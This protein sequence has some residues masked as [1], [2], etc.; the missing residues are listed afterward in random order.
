MMVLSR[1]GGVASTN[2][3][4]MFR[5]A[6]AFLAAGGTLPGWRLSR[7]D[8]ALRLRV[9]CKFMR[10]IIVLAMLA[11]PV[12]SGGAQNSALRPNILVILADQWRFDTCG[13]AGNADVKTPN[14]DRL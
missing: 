1:N 4:L 2:S 3:F 9:G 8:K 12:R 10:A 6:G 5:P 11:L 14:L 13:Y 7:C